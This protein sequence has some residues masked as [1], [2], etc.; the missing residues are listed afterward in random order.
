MT[1]T[2][3]ILPLVKDKS[4][5]GVASSLE[6]KRFGDDRREFQRPQQGT[7]ISHSTEERLD[8]D[9]A[10]GTTQTIAG[11]ERQ[12]YVKLSSAQSSEISQARSSGTSDADTHSTED[13]ASQF[14]LAGAQPKTAFF[15]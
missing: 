15:I 3:P 4:R 13:L 12:R 6:V 5:V 14:S 8:L 10:L 2:F 7:I 9:N 11:N 1:T